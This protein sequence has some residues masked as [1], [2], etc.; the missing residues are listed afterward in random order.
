M[1]RIHV[2][3]KPENV[4]KIKAQLFQW[5]F[6]IFDENHKSWTPK[7]YIEFEATWKLIRKMVDQLEK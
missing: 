3:L 7:Q 6:D 2:N 4:H 1:S 5:G